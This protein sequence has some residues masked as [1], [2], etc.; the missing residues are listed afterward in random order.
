MPPFRALI[1][2]AAFCLLAGCSIA[3]EHPAQ[4][5]AVPIEARCVE[6]EAS[7]PAGRPP[8]LSLTRSWFGNGD[9]WVG[10]PDYPAKVDG[11]AL[12]L[13]FP[14]VTFA[15]GAP[16]ATL[17]PPVVTA[18][19]RDAPGEATGRVEE[20]SRAFGTGEL[21]FWP[22]SVTFPEAGCWTVTGTIDDRTVEFVVEVS[23]PS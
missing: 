4:L 6:T 17:G 11:E 8:A 3:E 2:A 14:W 5:A 13:R 21:V 15:D 16:T 18:T 19:R 10:L 7:P 20:L 1:G 22:A 12:V 9:L 23:E